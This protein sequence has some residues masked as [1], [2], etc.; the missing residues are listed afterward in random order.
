MVEAHMHKV[1]AVSK[2]GML[3]NLHQIWL[4]THLKSCPL[5]ISSPKTYNLIPA[6]SS[7]A[8]GWCKLKQ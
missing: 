3:T 2:E 8:Q 4:V 5:T 6:T 1:L 7:D